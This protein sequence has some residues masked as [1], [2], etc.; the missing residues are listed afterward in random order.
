MSERLQRFLEP[1][2][3]NQ[4]RLT[5]DEFVALAMPQVAERTNALLDICR[6]AGPTDAARSVESVV[7]FFQTLIP[8]LGVES[9]SEVKRLVYR[10]APV[11]IQIAH[12]DF[13][14]DEVR[15]REGRSALA[16]LETV[17]LE[18]ASVRLTPGETELIF[19]SIDQM[20]AFIGVG[21]YAMASELI[22]SQLLSIIERNKL[23]RAL[24]RVMEV[25]VTIQKYLKERLGY[26]TPQ[27]RIPEDFETLAEYGPLR[28]FEEVGADGV[29]RHLIQVQ[30]PDIPILRDMVVHLA[31]SSGET[32]DVRLD[33]LGSAALTM[34]PGLYC[35][36][37]AY[38]P[39]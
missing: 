32:F 30:V 18:I 20:A 4:G 23:M 14:D 39:A 3:R 26:A 28:V 11:F 1:Q 24:F 31:A 37:I 15:R 21:E 25:E 22:S 10:L 16:S 6:D 35:L 9:T 13:S 19:K 34:A 2:G 38:E 36:G 8:T 12:N 27:L 7:V 17:L 5:E 29:S 33:A